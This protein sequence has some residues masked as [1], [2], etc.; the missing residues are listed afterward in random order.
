MT[1]PL[2]LDMDNLG[3]LSIESKLREYRNIHLRSLIIC[4]TH[5]W[6][7]LKNDASIWTHLN[8]WKYPKRWRFGVKTFTE[9][10]SLKFKTPV[11]PRNNLSSN[12]KSQITGDG[13]KKCRIKDLGISRLIRAQDIHTHKRNNSGNYLKKHNQI[14]HTTRR[15]GYRKYVVSVRFYQKIWKSARLGNFML[16]EFGKNSKQILPES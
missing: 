16:I 9:S 4:S 15:N 2:S 12:E 11:V 7:K 1:W 10:D 6:I 3:V 8:T 14:L 5:Y 13:N